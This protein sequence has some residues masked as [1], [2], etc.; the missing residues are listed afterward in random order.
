MKESR[1][2]RIERINY[3]DQINRV[4]KDNSSTSLELILN[5]EAIIKNI[6][7]YIHGGG[8]VKGDMSSGSY[9][10]KFTKEGLATVCLMNYPLQLTENHGNLIEL[11]LESIKA[12]IKKLKTKT[13]LQQVTKATIIGHSAGSYLTSLYALKEII[14]WEEINILLYDCAAYD[15]KEKFRLGN[16]KA[17]E[18]LQ[19][20][21]KNVD[22]SEI[23]NQYSPICVAE[24][25]NR[26]PKAKWYL[27]S[28]GGQMARRAANMMSRQLT[29]KGTSSKIIETNIEHNNIKQFIDAEYNGSSLIRGTING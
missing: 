10:S 22:Q 18:R 8:L 24:N 23:L 17:K 16:K 1:Q 29:L 19:D 2:L 15:L 28:G 7:V 6:I 4:M 25:K 12:G 13:E 9:L 3:S 26:N 20:I 14:P 27:I 11:Q 21:F 5:R